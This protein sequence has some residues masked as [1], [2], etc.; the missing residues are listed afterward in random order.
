[1]KPVSGGLTRRRLVATSARTCSVEDRGTTPRN[2]TWTMAVTINGATTTFTYT[3]Q[4]IDGPPLCGQ[5]KNR[6][7]AGHVTP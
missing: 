1:M 2:G 5:R 7:G 6:R 3:Y 4:V